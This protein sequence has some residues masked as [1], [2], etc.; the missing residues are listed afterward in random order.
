M[1]DKDTGK[2]LFN[3]DDIRV[4]CSKAKENQKTFNS[5]IGTQWARIS[6]ITDP[7]KKINFAVMRN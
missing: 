2:S 4:V 7:V 6:D 5:K 3:P 1:V